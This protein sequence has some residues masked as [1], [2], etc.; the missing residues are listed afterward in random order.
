MDHTQIKLNELT[1]VVSN[2]YHKNELDIYDIMF[3][4]VSGISA[5]IAQKSDGDF[6]YEN[7]VEKMKIMV[8][9]V[10]SQK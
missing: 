10:Q 6:D 7:M 8:K 4:Y 2:F 5:I 9:M 1:D 3:F